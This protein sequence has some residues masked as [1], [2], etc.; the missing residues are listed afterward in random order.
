MPGTVLSSR[1]APASKT[2]ISALL[3]LTFQHSWVWVQC[4]CLCNRR[5]RD[6]K[7]NRERKGARKEGIPQNRPPSLIYPQ[8]RAGVAAGE[9]TLSWN[10]W[11][12]PGPRPYPK[13]CWLSKNQVS[14]E[15][16]LDMFSFVSKGFWLIQLDISLE[17]K[18]S[19][20]VGIKNVTYFIS[21]ASQMA[22]DPCLSSWSRRP[23]KWNKDCKYRRTQSNFPLNLL[24]LF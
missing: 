16:Q 18:I 10:S 4:L 11:L 8:L 22:L 5:R 19:T 2:K 13:R 1:E 3:E 14:L 17:E 9:I 21:L 24:C 12:H 15:G 6:L 23:L 20:L 7:K